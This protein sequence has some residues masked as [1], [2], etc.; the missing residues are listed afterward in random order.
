[1]KVFVKGYPHFAG[2]LADRLRQVDKN[3][4]YIH[5][6]PGI[7][8]QKAITMPR[9]FSSDVAYFI[10]GTIGRNWNSFYID[11]F[12]NLNKTVIMH[13]V[14]TDVLNA[15]NCYKK[16]DYCY[17]Y[18]KQVIHFCEVSWIKD[19]LLEIG[20]KADVV[21]FATFED[22][23]SM[24]ITMPNNFRV[25]SYMPNGREKYYGIDYLIKLAK[26]FPNIEI[27]ITSLTECNE[28]IPNNIKLL[29]YVKDI[30]EEYKNSVLYLRLP[31]HD[32]LAFSV[33]EAL[34]NGRYVGYSYPFESTFHIDSYEKLK[35]IVSNLYDKFTQ[36]L[37]SINYGGIKFIKDNYDCNVIL[38]NLINKLVDISLNR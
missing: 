11:I 18:I 9:I 22:K 8:W 29:G 37:L 21:P 36:G 14:G 20:I 32:G 3:N 19:E 7:Y 38:S 25:L 30:S 27:R 6:H 23:I 17:K 16:G 35:E 4:E 1:M 24:P 33:L 10:G 2:P 26:D 13:W 34:A 12:I 31:R 15:I 5:L 28:V